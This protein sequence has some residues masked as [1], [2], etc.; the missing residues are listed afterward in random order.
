M[1]IF[2][3]S[4]GD[5]SNERADGSNNWDVSN[6]L[7]SVPAEGNPPR[8]QAMPHLAGVWPHRFG[9]RRE[10]LRK[11]SKCASL[12]GHHQLGLSVHTNPSN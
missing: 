9:F 3:T 5:S 2:A 12:A 10:S 8:A 11:T 4:T 1:V 7:G 6:K